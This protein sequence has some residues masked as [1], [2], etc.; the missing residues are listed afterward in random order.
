MSPTRRGRLLISTS[1]RALSRSAVSPAPWIPLS[2][3]GVESVSARYSLR[4]RCRSARR[5]GGLGLVL[6]AIA[7]LLQ[8]ALAILHSPVLVGSA[9][10]AGD[11][12]AGFDEHAL[13]LAQGRGDPD[14]G[15]P[16]DQAPQPPRSRTCGVLLLAWQHDL[17]ARAAHYHR[18]GRVCSI[19]RRF[20]VAD[21]GR[22]A[23]PGRHHSRSRATGKSLAPPP[24]D[25]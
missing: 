2:E 11:L 12:A 13:C 23:S 9:E 24:P 20:H 14:A 1:Q 15:T 18:A 4:A 17:G 8:V 22:P 5:P 19:G 3:I 6:A 16:A 25:R 10:L 7:L 21:G